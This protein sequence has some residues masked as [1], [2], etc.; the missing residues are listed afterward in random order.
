VGSVLPL[1]LLN[2][3]QPQ[4]GLIDERRRLQAVADA[5]SRHAPFGYPVQLSLDQRH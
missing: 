5:F 3:D 2:I 4:V 1:D